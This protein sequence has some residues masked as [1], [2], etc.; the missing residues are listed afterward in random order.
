MSTLR[1]TDQALDDIERIAVYVA[2]R[3]LAAAIQLSDR[4]V[5]AAEAHLPTNPLLGRPGRVG[6][7]RELVVHANYMLVYVIAEDRVEVLTVR[8]VARAWPDG[9]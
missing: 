5:D 8:H 2:E 3:D 1:W 7:T 4:I 6:G 9:F